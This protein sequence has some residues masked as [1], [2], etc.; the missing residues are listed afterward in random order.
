MMR[1]VPDRRDICHTRFNSFFV[2]FY[3]APVHRHGC[4]ERI[5]QTSSLMS[6][7]RCGFAKNNYGPCATHEQR[8]IAVE[9]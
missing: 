4:I 8:F 3:S 6:E 7:F 2:I 9:N 1:R 5:A